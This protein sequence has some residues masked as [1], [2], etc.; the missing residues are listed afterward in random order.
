[1]TGLMRVSSWSSRIRT[2]DAASRAPAGLPAARGKEGRVSVTG[3]YVAAVVLLAAVVFV[4]VIAMR[5]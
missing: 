1:M 4:W 5:H 2:R 3:I